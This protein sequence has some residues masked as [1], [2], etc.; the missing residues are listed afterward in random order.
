MEFLVRRC[1]LRARARNLLIA[2]GLFAH[3]GAVAMAAPSDPAPPLDFGAG[4]LALQERAVQQST[5]VRAARER[6]L[7]AQHEVR[8]EGA[9]PD[10]MVSYGAGFMD[11]E[12]GSVPQSHRVGIEQRLPWFG[13][14]GERREVATR[15]AEAERARYEDVALQLR[16]DVALAIHDAYL[17]AR[18]IEITADNL[19]LLAQFESVSLA[20]FRVG[21]AENADLLRLQVEMGKVED[22]LR[23]LRELERPLHARLNAL[24]D[25]PSGAPWSSAPLLIDRPQLAAEDSLRA[26]L[27]RHHPRLLALDAE[28]AQQEH[29]TELARREGF[30]DLTVGVLHTFQRETDP[31]NPMVRA[32]ETMAMV[33]FNLPLWRGRIGA[34]V[35]ASQGRRSAV[36]AAR[37]DE[38]NRLL[39]ELEQ[40]LYEH[41]D[42]SRRVE[43][44]RDTLLPKAEESLRANLTSFELGRADFSALIDT[45]RTLLE[46]RLALSRAEVDRANAHARI[47]RL[48]PSAAPTL[49]S[50]PNEESER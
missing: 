40:N 24:F 37:R 47:D 29:A 9:L 15:F 6:W 26:A 50:T 13:V 11:V 48:A 18:S 33:A 46:F 5:A 32:D 22:Q 2:C 21:N 34:R 36:L 7:A 12:G 1:P 45:E 28:A 30:P 41:R 43:L 10:P 42:A 16:L 8:G 25:R 17:L 31:P 38:A 35:A 20:R 14:R 23:Q 49:G 3:G 44:Y 4:V 39:A 27:L 19:E